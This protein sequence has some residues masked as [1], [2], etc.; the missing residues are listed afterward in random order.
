MI[1]AG[2]AT[3]R[4]ANTMRQSES[5]SPAKGILAVR[6]TGTEEQASVHINGFKIGTT[7]IEIEQAAGTVN[8]M[9]S[10][11]RR[12]VVV[13]QQ[14][15]L[16]AGKRSHV[17]CEPGYANLRINGPRGSQVSI[18]GKTEVSVPV[19]LERTMEGYYELVWSRPGRQ[20]KI[21]RSLTLKAGEQRVINHWK[22]IK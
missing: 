5:Q 7:P 12:Q 15:D 8:L 13:R 21:S 2:L 4:L 10:F 1:A 22:E 11:E 20:K 17:L 9:C 14:V 16:L 18:D 3:G 19:S 6:A